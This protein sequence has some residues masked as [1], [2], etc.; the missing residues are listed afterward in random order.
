M[1]GHFCR[2]VQKREEPIITADQAIMGLRIL[3]AISESARTGETVS[4]S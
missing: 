3:K 4:F 1:T 2:V